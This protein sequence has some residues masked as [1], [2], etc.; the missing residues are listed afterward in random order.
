[1]TDGPKWREHLARHGLLAFQRACAARPLTVH[2]GRFLFLRHGE[3]NGNHQ[4]IIQAPTIEL[5]DTGRRQA[6]RAAT[7]LV[8]RG[9]QRIVASTVNRAWESANIVGREIGV[10]PQP[11]D[12][13]R[14]RNFG[15][16]IGSPSHDLN[17]ANNPPNGETMLQFVDRVQSGV[18]EALESDES[19]LLIAHGGTLYA[20]AYSLGVEVH[21]DMIGNATPL[22][23]TRGA[24]GWKAE[25][26]A[27][28][29]DSPRDDNIG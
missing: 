20:L 11:D 18:R 2:A 29:D 4:R 14:E 6:A 27:A 24:A 21:Q 16:L 7:Q 1:M 10:T 13:L 23:F 17:W 3:T 5:N 15:D 9:V 8:G 28:N 12:R 25:H 26:L 22:V 19:T